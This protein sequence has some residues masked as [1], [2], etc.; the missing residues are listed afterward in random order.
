VADRKTIVAEVVG[1]GD[2]HKPAKYGVKILIFAFSKA[3]IL[4]HFI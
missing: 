2:M 4:A 1:N 3:K